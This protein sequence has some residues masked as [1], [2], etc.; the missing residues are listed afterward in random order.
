MEKYLAQ[1]TQLINASG[2][3]RIWN[4][5]ATIKDPIDFSIGQ[6]DFD[7]PEPLKAEAIAAIRSG[8]NRYSLTAGDQRLQAAV[9]ARVTAEFG[10][11]EPAT[12]VAS[13]IS[14]A[15][16][17]LFMSL[18]DPG[19]EVI[20]PDPYF[21]M[22]KHVIGML[23][24]KCVFVNSY[25]DFTLPVD[26]IASAITRR[27]K[28][29]IVNSPCN[30]TG[31]VYSADEMKALA[32][33][34]GDKNII[35]MSDEI[36]DHFCYDA[37]YHSMASYYDRTV[38]MRGFSKSYGVPGWRLAYVA[39]PRELKPL[40]DEMTKIQQYTFVCAPTPFQIA[41]IKALDY[42]MTEIIKAYKRKRDL[43]Y[44]G[45]KDRFEVRKPG[46]SFYTFVKA[47]GRS[48]S[49]FVEKAILNKVLV[50]PGNVFSEQDTH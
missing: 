5:A 8:Q 20:V 7:V 31:A 29:I 12:M 30:P 47:P 35:V 41:A 3:R 18:I 14:G 37:P 2:I 46:G 36:Y 22:Y 33:V 32:R 45:L 23:G 48:A 19:D 26:K 21:V 42:D 1:R 27:T 40:I 25:P 9:Q 16:F 28:L 6:P 34:A 24:G 11:P 17:L 39:M 43:V 44:E 15:M 50:I 4:I 49:E 10:W 13:G 38:L